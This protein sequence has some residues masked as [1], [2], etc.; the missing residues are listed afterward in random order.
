MAQ[1]ADN[2]CVTIDW[3]TLEI[4]LAVAAGAA[5]AAAIL[6]RRV[7]R[8]N[9]LAG[10]RNGL[11]VAIAI[12][13]VVGA[14]A[15]LLIGL[16]SPLSYG[17]VVGLAFGG[18]YF[19]AGATLM[20]LG[21]LAR[22]GADWARYGAWAAVVVVTFSLGMGYVAYNAFKDASTSP[23]QTLPT[24]TLPTQTA[25]ATGGTSAGSSVRL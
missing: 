1:L 17:L 9:A 22:G 18:G 16:R 14:L 5:W 19:L 25:P 11:V 2:G 24:Q 20:P 7:D 4:A 3:V 8:G 10:L 21:F 15:T 6:A 23:T 13:V 12:G